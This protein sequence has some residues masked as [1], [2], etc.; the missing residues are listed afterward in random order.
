MMSHRDMMTHMSHRDIQLASPYDVPLRWH[1]VRTEMTSSMIII[2]DAHMMP[3]LPTGPE[4]VYVTPG[5]MTERIS[6]I[7][8]EGSMSSSVITLAKLDCAAVVSFDTEQDGQAAYDMVNDPS[9]ASAVSKQPIFCCNAS[10]PA[11]WSD[12]RQIVASGCMNA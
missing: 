4:H 12:G 6:E 8:I 10:W 7:I 9:W 1:D 11:G 3:R 5:T 2:P